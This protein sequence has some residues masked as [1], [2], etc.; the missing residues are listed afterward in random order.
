MNLSDINTKVNRLTKADTTDYPNA[1]RLIDLN[2]WNQKVVTW[3]LAAQDSSDFDDANHTGYSTLSTDLVSGQRDYNFGISDGVVGIKRVEISYD[4]VNAY[5]STPIDSSE[6][7]T[8]LMESYTDIDNDFSTS[9]PGHD[10]KYNSLFIYPKPTATLGKIEVEVSRTARDFTSGEF[11]TGTITPG[12]DNNFHIVLAYGMAYEYALENLTSE[13]ATDIM[14]VISDYK[15][16]IILQYG[17]KE[18]NKPLNFLSD[19]E[20]YN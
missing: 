11:T 4:G 9:A 7:Q 10:W 17:K 3:I 20:N 1:N 14:N 8:P 15:K 12:F 13:K 2:A 18:Q 5:L 16:S 6:I 19:Y